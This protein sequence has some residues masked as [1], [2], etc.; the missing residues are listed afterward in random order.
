MYVRKARGKKPAHTKWPPNDMAGTSIFD[1]YP[2]S[3]TDN[4]REWLVPE[5][6]AKEKKNKFFSRIE[7]IFSDS[8]PAVTKEWVIP[9]LRRWSFDLSCYSPTLYEPSVSSTVRT[10]PVSL[11]VGRQLSPGD[12]SS[13]HG[14]FGRRSVRG[15][16]SWLDRAARHTDP[17]ASYWKTEQ[18]LK[19]L[20]AAKVDRFYKSGFSVKKLTGPENYFAW[21]EEMQ[22]K[23]SQ[24]RAWA[25]LEDDLDQV[26]VISKFRTRWNQLNNKAWLLLVANVSREIRRDLCASWAWDTR[27]SW[28]YLREK[29]GG[30]AATMTRS[31]QGVRDMSSLEYEVCSS[32]G[33]FLGKMEE[34][35]QAIECNRRKKEVDEWLWCR[36]ILAKLGPQW[37]PW[38]SEYMMKMQHAA[39]TVTV[40]QLLLDIEA[41]EARR[42]R[43]SRR[44]VP[45]ID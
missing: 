24:C 41:E 43:A 4:P 12:A 10:L 40:D 7:E 23:L 11:R 27:G 16:I 18:Y 26:P 34:C 33:E 17:S 31:V 6:R 13:Y 30:F 39:S 29:Y 8:D 45:K 36:F 37:E 42:V 9:G 1:H 15:S 2:N 20:P 5:R 22:A 21:A 38:V 25:I 14:R 35:I 19:R 44:P 32:L 3:P 28:C